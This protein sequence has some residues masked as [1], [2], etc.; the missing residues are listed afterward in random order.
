MELNNVG[1]LFFP[2]CIPPALS[3]VQDAYSVSLALFCGK[4]E[5]VAEVYSSA[6]MQPPGTAQMLKR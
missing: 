3:A 6:F 5:I 2:P 1:V 4:I